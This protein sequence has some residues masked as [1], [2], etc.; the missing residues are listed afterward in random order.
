MS[1]QQKNGN[2][3]ATNGKKVETTLNIV[4]PKN[5]ETKPLPTVPGRQLSDLPPVE[6]RVLKVQQLFDLATKREKLQESLKKLKSIK[7]SSDN[8]DLVITI[9]GDGGQWETYNTDAIKVC[10]A[11]M[12]VTIKEK[13]DEVE[14]Q[15]RF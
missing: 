5:E 3:L 13:L 7:A 2:G 1:T 10:I 14:K 11:A 4:L 6:D 8:R 15:I 9:E 12:E